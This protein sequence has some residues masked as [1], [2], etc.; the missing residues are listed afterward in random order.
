[1]QSAGGYLFQHWSRFEDWRE[2]L[3]KRNVGTTLERRGMLC[4]TSFVLTADFDFVSVDLDGYIA[5][6][7]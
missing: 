7:A 1:M 4:Y 3:A 5:L 2:M 6:A